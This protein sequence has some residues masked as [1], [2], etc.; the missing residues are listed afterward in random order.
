MRFVDPQED[1][2]RRHEV[3]RA[4]APRPLERAP[5]EIDVEIPGAGRSR[6]F[7][8]WVTE[9]HSTSL[10][11]LSGGSVVHEWYADGVGPGSLLLG[12]SMTKSALAHLVGRAVGAGSL[13][14]TDVVGNLVPELAGSGYAGCTVEHLLTMTTGTAWTEDHRDPDGPATRLVACF[15]G[16]QER[17]RELLV[18]VRPQDPPGTRWEYSTADSQVLDWARERATGQTYAEALGDLWAELGCVR[19]AVVGVDVAG[20][21]LAGG[22]L[23]ACAEDWLRLAALQLEPT[24]WAQ[25][26]STPTQPW[27]EPGRL[28]SSITT[29]AGFGY[30][31]WPLSADGSR[32]TADGSRGQ[33][34]YA[35]RDRGVAVVK[36][37]LWPYD[38]PWVD[39]QQRD[40][41]YLG[42]PLVAAAVG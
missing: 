42:L 15:G 20:V 26:S 25:A 40:L 8:D 7:A 38:D 39:R 11:V 14:V 27:L 41:S 6:P 21:A 3:V 18:Q 37:S 19:D 33:F 28:P 24:A 31:W 30:H 29:H 13:R 12:A 4:S 23:A 32:V 9:T 34:G 35:D 16:T 1:A 17:S 5:R 10:L 2:S 22:G 36:T